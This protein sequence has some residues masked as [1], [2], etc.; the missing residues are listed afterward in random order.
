MDVWHAHSLRVRRTELRKAKSLVCFHLSFKSFAV[1]AGLPPRFQSLSSTLS[2]KLGIYWLISRRNSSSR[3]CC[4]LVGL[5]KRPA[6]AKTSQSSA[7][8]CLSSLV[9][10]AP[11]T[12]SG[13]AASASSY[14]C[15]IQQLPLSL[16]WSYFFTS[17]TKLN[18]P[19][20]T[21]VIVSHQGLWIS[22]TWC[23]RVLP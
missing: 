12:G 9:E 8:L 13:K 16:R 10:Q 3:N 23:C 18:G 22:L 20:G 2:I 4:E 14:L 17:V 21:A 11:F 5:L 1:Y 6:S 19:D 15:N 7:C